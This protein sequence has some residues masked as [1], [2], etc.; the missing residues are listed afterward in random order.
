MSQSSRATDIG[1]IHA[2]IEGRVQGVGFR[3]FLQRRA[4]ELDLSGWVR[5][6]PDGCVELVAEGP[7]EDLSNLLGAAR[8]GPR[9]AYVSSVRVEWLPPQRNLP[10]P[11]AI[12]SDSWG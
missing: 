6:T 5:N 7:V 3:F 4:I 11:F 2:R 1:R 10:K 12:H 9:S 8:I